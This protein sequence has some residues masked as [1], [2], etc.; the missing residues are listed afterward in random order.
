ML[1]QWHIAIDVGHKPL[2]LVHGGKRHATSALRTRLL[3]RKRLAAG[4]QFSD[5]EIRIAASQVR[6]VEVPR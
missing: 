5:D 4:E 6:E 1:L 2:R 3:W